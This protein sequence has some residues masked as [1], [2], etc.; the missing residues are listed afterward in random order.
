MLCAALC[1]PSLSANATPEDV[2]RAKE[3]VDAHNAEATQEAERMRVTAE[4][5][6]A[7]NRSYRFVEHQRMWKLAGGY[8][9]TAALG[10]KTY[11]SPNYY[12]VWPWKPHSSSDES[13]H[14]LPA[15]EQEKGE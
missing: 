11:Y 7:I 13:P 4:Q 5:Q 3:F 2:Q 15:E 1:G 14:N 10:G 12:A 9:F 6:K 8:T